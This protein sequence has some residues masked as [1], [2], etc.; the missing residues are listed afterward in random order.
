MLLLFCL[1]LLFKDSDFHL[2]K[3]N[4]ITL[5]FKLRFQLF[6]ICQELFLL[7]IASF[8]NGKKEFMLLDQAF[9][10]LLFGFLLRPFDVALSM[11]ATPSSER[12]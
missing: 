9:T 10:S 2:D 11:V 7:E 1:E 3:H 8:G 6:Y 4:S 5:A 12:L